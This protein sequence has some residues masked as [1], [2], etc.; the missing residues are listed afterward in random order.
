M[1]IIKKHAVAVAKM[2]IFMAREGYYPMS[3][4]EEDLI[5]RILSFAV[6][7]KMVTKEELCSTKNYGDCIKIVKTARLDLTGEDLPCIMEVYTEVSA[8]PNLESELDD[9]PK[10]IKYLEKTFGT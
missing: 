10:S 1:K 9:M 3:P 8:D 2:F 4:S 7:H 5:S 6:Y